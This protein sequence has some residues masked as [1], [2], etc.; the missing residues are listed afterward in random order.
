MIP[1][2]PHTQKLMDIEALKE[3]LKATLQESRDIDADHDSQMAEVCSL[4]KEYFFE[5]KTKEEKDKVEF[6]ILN[7]LDCLDSLYRGIEEVGAKI[8]R[9]EYRI[10]QLKE[11]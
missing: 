1:L 9:L 3:K 5:A 4:T 6:E 8:N 11:V 7:G 10:A 2:N